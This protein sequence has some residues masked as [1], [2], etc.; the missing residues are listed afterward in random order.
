VKEYQFIESRRAAWEAWD[1]WLV[2]GLR[3]KGKGNDASDAEPPGSGA[4]T[5]ESLP[6]E[7]RGLCRDLSLAR[8][9]RYS[10]PLLDALRD[11]VLAVH[12]RI[13]GARRAAG[14]QWLRF[15][16]HDF[17]V[18][19]RSEAR[20]VWAS[21]ALFFLPLFLALYTLQFY[22]DGVYFLLTPET[23]GSA[24]EMYAPTAERLGRP[25]EASDDVMMLGFYIGNNVRIDFQ[26]FAGGIVFGLGSVFFL[27]YNGLVIGAVAGHLTQIGY[28]ETFWGFVA[29]HSAPELIGAV[30]SGAAGLKIGLAL[31]APGR[32]RRADALKQAARQ[33]VHLL[34]GAAGLTFCA[35]FV[36]A[37][38]SPMRTVPVEIKYGFGIAF[39]LALLAYF[40]LVGRGRRAA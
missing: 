10:E 25:R 23:V 4:I 20:L 19:V 38:W 18:L 36:E 13:Y 31:I 30:L 29:G 15:V 1:R 24:E 40:S 26:C 7:F 5:A 34:Y 21:A 27:I 9:R 28:I 8:D 12:Q 35:A 22:P 39:W 17:P 11:R 3:G 2:G 37:F 6:R 33:A 14:G 16:L 32:L